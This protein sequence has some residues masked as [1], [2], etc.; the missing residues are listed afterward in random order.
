M[1]LWRP[2]PTWETYYE[3]SFSGQV[4]RIASGGSTYP[5]RILKGTPNDDGYIRV[6]LR[7]P[8]HREMWFIHEL[9]ALTFIGPKPDNREVNHKNRVKT[10]N[11]ATNLEYITHQKN[12]V[13]AFAERTDH[14]K[15]ERN[16]NSKLIE[17][18]VKDIRSRFDGSNLKQ[19]ATEYNIGIQQI[20]QIVK[21]TN[22]KHI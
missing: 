3:A 15:G 12:C 7:K 8:G 13:H 17:S 16:P 10:D 1:E 20:R 5:G 21:R 11:N 6:G 4:R 22:W 2:I 18:Q 19:L 14:S 9:I